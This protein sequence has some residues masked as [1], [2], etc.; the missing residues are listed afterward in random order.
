[1]NFYVLEALIVV[2]ISWIPLPPEVSFFASSNLSRCDFP[3]NNWLLTCA[4]LLLV[5][6]LL[7]VMLMQGLGAFLMV[8]LDRFLRGKQL[9]FLHSQ[10]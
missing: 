9:P 6:L 7:L 10:R 5:K 3:I 8:T 2:P 4:L 1:M